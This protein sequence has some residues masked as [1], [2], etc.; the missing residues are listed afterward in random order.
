MS[1]TPPAEIERFA[2]IARIALRH[3]GLIDPVA[4]FLRFNENITFRVTAAAGRDRYLLRIHKSATSNFLVQSPASLESELLWLE[5]LAR[6]T[7]IVVQQ[8]IRNKRGQMVTAITPIGETA[9]LL[10]TLLTWI[11][12]GPFPREGDDALPL[13]ERLGELA[14]RL[15][16]H[17]GR[18]TVP[19]GFTRVTYGPEFLKRT[20]TLLKDGVERGLIGPRDMAVLDDVADRIRSIIAPLPRD[21][22]SWGL[23]HADLQGNNILVHEGDVRA[24]DFS[25][26]GFGHFLFDL[27]VALSCVKPD[28]REPLMNGYCRHR[29]LP[30][31]HM[32][33]VEAFALFGMLNCFAFLLPDSQSGN[34]IRRRVPEVAGTHCLAWLD[35]KPILATL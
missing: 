14:A 32:Q 5:A 20:I 23:I 26:C 10:C 12:G 34:W 1:S 16:E 8:P 21:R 27:A 3:Y 2:A 25:L 33:F 28:L 18:C 22:Q 31:D 13:A 15:H 11:D 17:A 9:P 29:A 6:D 7:D 19:A 24:I 30:A 4:Q 35:G